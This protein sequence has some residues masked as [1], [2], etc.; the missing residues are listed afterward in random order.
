MPRC[1]RLICVKCIELGIFAHDHRRF[2]IEILVLGRSWLHTHC[3]LLRRGDAS[4]SLES[5]VIVSVSQVT[6]DALFGLRL[7]LLSVSD[8][9]RS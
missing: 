1:V 5:H 6:I 2:G 9:I 7:Y 4:P 3:N 8:R